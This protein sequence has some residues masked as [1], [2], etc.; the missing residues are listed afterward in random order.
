MTHTCFDD[1]LLTLFFF[2]VEIDPSNDDDSYHNGDR[3]DHAGCFISSLR[4][5]GDTLAQYQVDLNGS[6]VFSYP[7][8]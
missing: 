6:D 2:E 4:S 1:F 3:V 5:I 7:T 8:Y